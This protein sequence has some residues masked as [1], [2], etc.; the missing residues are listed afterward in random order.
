MLQ[1]ILTLM[2]STSS[3]ALQDARRNNVPR[4]VE[5]SVAELIAE[6]ERYDR[7]IVRTRVHWVQLYHGSLACPLGSDSNCIRI[8]LDCGDKESCKSMR[9]T[10]AANLAGGPLEDMRAKFVV[11]GR[12]VYIKTPASRNGS[13]FLLEV[14]E[15]EDVLPKSAR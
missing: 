9:D 12:F 10:L 7:R 11:V 3:L 5:A 6:P 13:Q 14:S 15:I 4:P 1:I 8:N 2:L